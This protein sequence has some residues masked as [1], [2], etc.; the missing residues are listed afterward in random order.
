M[1]ESGRKSASVVTP[2][3]HSL[4]PRPTKWHLTIYSYTYTGREESTGKQWLPLSGQFGGQQFGTFCHPWLV[5]SVMMG[6]GLR[7]E[8][9]TWTSAGTSDWPE[10]P[11]GK[12]LGKPP[13][14]GG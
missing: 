1:A 13:Q 14:A 3:K 4:R 7:A 6:L 12:I 8:L 2:S 9:S 5:I 10:K 11:L